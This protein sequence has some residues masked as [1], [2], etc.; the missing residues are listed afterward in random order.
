MKTN[1]NMR[2]HLT[3]LFLQ[4]KMFQTKVSWKLKTRILY[5]GTFFR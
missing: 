1:V 3:E 4:W 5:S 2:Q